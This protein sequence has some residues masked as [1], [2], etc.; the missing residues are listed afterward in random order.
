MANILMIGRLSFTSNDVRTS[1]I[2]GRYGSEV[3]P[4]RYDDNIN[5]SVVKI[6]SSLIEFNSKIKKILDN[7]DSKGVMI[8]QK[9]YM[10]VEELEP[11]TDYYRLDKEDEE[12][13]KKWKEWNL[14]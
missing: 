12:L 4:G 5:V 7:A 13:L 11:D 10:D 1:V 3:F 2:K 6:N 8:R 9:K 14:K